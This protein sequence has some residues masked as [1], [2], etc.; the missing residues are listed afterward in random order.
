[1]HPLTLA[2]CADEAHQFGYSTGAGGL[3]CRPGLGGT[4]YRAALVNHGSYTGV[5]CTATAYGARGL[6]LFSGPLQFAFGGPRGLFAPAHWAMTF[7]WYL[8][9]RTADRVRAYQASCSALGYP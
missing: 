8:P 3:L 2:A 5:S 4:W 6:V 1:M 9:H 7:T